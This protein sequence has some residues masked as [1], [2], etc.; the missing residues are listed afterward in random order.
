MANRSAKRA[1]GIEIKTESRGAEAKVDKHNGREQSPRQ[2]GSARLRNLATERRYELL[3]RMD[4]LRS[5][6]IGLKLES[7]RYRSLEPMY[8][9]GLKSESESE[10][11]LGS[12][13]RRAR[14][15]APENAFRC[16]HSQIVRACGCNISI[17]SVCQ[18]I[19]PSVR[20]SVCSSRRRK[21]CATK[22]LSFLERTS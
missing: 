11:A 9:S 1:L 5:D 13:V 14:M 18:S 21:F 15:R 6:P 19:C 16:A 12:F 22:L 7:E 2:L 8:R 10:E 20:L 17:L 4:P 3:R